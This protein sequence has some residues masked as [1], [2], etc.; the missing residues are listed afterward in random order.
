MAMPSIKPAA[1]V[2]E[3]AT[4]SPPDIVRGYRPGLIARI[5]LMHALYYARASGFGQR[6]ES[7]VAGGLA[8]FCGRLD[9]PRNAIWAAML[10]DEIV[11]SI[12]VD[13]EDLGGNVAHLRWFIMDDQARGSGVGRRLLS[14]AL[15]FADESGFSETQLWTF[16]GLSAA[17]HLY[18]TYGFSCVEERPGDQWGT[19][20]L[21]QRFVRHADLGRSS[22]FT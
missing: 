2:T 3:D 20:V 5:T 6:F 21:E 7:V 8:E 19:E 11:G 16:K 13:G 4:S 12:A 22:K 18:E 17:R 15:A 1:L 14:A 9:N 10:G